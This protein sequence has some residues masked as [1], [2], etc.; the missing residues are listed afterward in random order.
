[1]QVVRSG[2]KQPGNV[3]GASHVGS[4]LLLCRYG[5]HAYGCLSSPLF[6]IGQQSAGCHIERASRQYSVCVAAVEHRS[7]E[8]FYNTRLTYS[9]VIHCMLCEVKFDNPKQGL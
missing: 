8:H 2:V 7:C 4:S 3:W 6:L 5:T 1:T 9:A